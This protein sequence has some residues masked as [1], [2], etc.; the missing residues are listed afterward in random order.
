MLE[1]TVFVVD[2]D[3]AVRD[4]LQF[5]LES[6]DLRVEAFESAERFLKDYS[7]YQVGCL[8]LDIR[9]PGMNG[10][11][12]QK[13]LS[14]HKYTLPIIIIS[15]HGDI[16]AAVR[17]MRR[18][19]MDFVEKPFNNEDLLGHVKAALE[20]DVDNQQKR[21]QFDAIRAR[22]DN[23]TPREH[24][25]M[26]LVVKDNP[27]KV[28]ASELGVS[29]KTVEFHRARVMEKM[30]ADSLLHLVAMVREVASF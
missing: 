23:L 4:S 30:H 6:E 9:M 13:E 15:G 3:Q 28:I 5:L 26:E 17:A 12:L 27:N 2:D 25:V 16:P 11:E 18:G 10:L 14:K 8:L 21:M 20:R 24:Q 22:V 7:I 19:A 29:I 1:P